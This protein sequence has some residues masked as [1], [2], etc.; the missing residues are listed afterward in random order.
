MAWEEDDTVRTPKKGYHYDVPRAPLIPQWA[1]IDKGTK[2]QLFTTPR[3]SPVQFRETF[4]KLERDPTFILPVNRLFATFQVFSSPAATPKDWSW[5]VQVLKRAQ[6]A[7]GDRWEDVPLSQTLFRALQGLALAHMAEYDAAAANFSISIAVALKTRPSP[8]FYKH[9]DLMVIEAYLK[10]MKEVGRPEDIASMVRYA[11]PRLHGILS[12]RTGSFEYKAAIRR[13]RD[14]FHESL[15]DLRNPEEWISAQLQPG[16]DGRPPKSVYHVALAVLAALT[17]HPSRMSDA[18]YFWRHIIQQF[19]STIV[20]PATASKL[21]STLA[22]AGHLDAAKEVFNA[23]RE[24]VAAPPH[25]T[26]SRELWMYAE[27]GEPDNAR[28]LFNEINARYGPTRDDRLA[29]STAYAVTGNV[30]ATHDTLVD[31]F[32]GGAADEVDTLAVLQRACVASGDAEA[33]HQYLDKSIKLRPTIEPFL[34]L[35]RLHGDQGNVDA[36][37]RVFERLLETGIQLDARCYTALVSAFGKSRDYINATKVFRAMVEAG[38]VPNVAAWR[39]L[40]NA[41]VESG[42]WALAADLCGT[43]PP[44]LLKDPGLAT[45]VL[46]A[47]VYVAAPFESIMRL[48]RSLASP[49]APAWALIIQA[50]ADAGNIVKARDLFYEMDNRAQTNVF[51]PAPNVYVF[52]I[53][54]AAYLRSGD[55]QSARS[56][57]DAMIERK[58]APTSVTYAIIVSAYADSPGESS[59]EQAHNFAMSV[60]NQPFHLEKPEPQGTAAENIFGPL[61]TAAARAGNTERAKAY[62]DEIT[63]LQGHSFRTSTKLMNAYLKGGET[64]NLYR[65]WLRLFREA[66][67]TIPRLNPEQLQQDGLR[68]EER[69]NVLCIP[70]STTLWGLANAGLHDRIRSV[71]SS[72]RTAGF[73]FDATNYNDY[74]LALART[75]HV[76]EAFE[77]VDRVLMP[78]YDEVE[79]REVVSLRPPSGLQPVDESVV[80]GVGMASAEAASPDRSSLEPIDSTE[81]EFTYDCKLT[82]DDAAMGRYK[83][84]NRRGEIQ[85]DVPPQWFDPLADDELSREEFFNLDIL[86]QWRPAD[87]H[88]RPSRRTIAVL[89]K[90]YQQIEDQRRYHAWVGIGANDESED[91]STG[92]VTLPEFGNTTVKKPDGS[93]QTMSP[94]LILARL[95]SKYARLVGLIMFRRRKKGRHD[96]KRA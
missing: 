24:T 3:P 37:V 38:H 71:W 70:L 68:R 44:E 45:T 83:E 13:L 84:P 63:S 90:T 96:R 52:S 23:L 8:D 16:R 77:I 39:A 36:A 86:R 34:S 85:P 82:N 43:I 26:L 66:K 12:Q 53:L 28:R 69:S 95:N 35:L 47:F 32:G 55:R 5:L 6:D 91:G 58:I 46:K 73:G 20:P 59:F 61:I 15:S 30:E 18:F 57:Y 21:G 81:A 11:G 89:D 2:D 9:W 56:V 65:T 29:L 10:L 27:A 94:S 75:G 33:A 80:D 51:A 88:W 25:S 42:Q 64:K 7:V 19:N 87:I 78:R 17:N 4:N 14:L 54:L 67:K 31:M 22:R 48:F 50:A 74:A 76:E 41:Y 79:G 72:V 49:S 93:P 92:P 1:H 60:L 40:L 62:F